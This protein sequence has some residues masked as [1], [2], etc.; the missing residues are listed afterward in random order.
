MYRSNLDQR[1]KKKVVRRSNFGSRNVCVG[2]WLCKNAAERDGDRIDVSPNC[3]QV[4][5][6]SQACSI[7]LNLRK[8]ILVVSRFFEFL[9]SQGHSL[10]M[11]LVSAPHHV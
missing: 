2:S 4:R 8:I 1:R 5:K 7:F 10:P 9:H 3:V 6:D 11:R